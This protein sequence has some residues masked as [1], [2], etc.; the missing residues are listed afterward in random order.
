[1]FTHAGY[2]QW[3]SDPAVN[4]KIS[5]AAGDQQD[6]RIASDN[7]GGAII[8]WEDYRADAANGAIY[9]QRINSAGVTQWTTDGVQVCATAGINRTMPAIL[10]DGTGG[11]LIV[12]QDNRNG[13][14]DLFA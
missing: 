6:E 13:D 14:K 12:W 9:A 1:T 10:E 7:K 5:S 3:S 2:S 8:V 11:A 4:V